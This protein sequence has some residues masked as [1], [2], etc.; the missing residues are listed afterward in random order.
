MEVLLVTQ[1]SAGDVHPAVGIGVELAARGHRVVVGANERFAETIAAAGLKL[2]ALG[3]R[4][5]Y[6]SAAASPELFDGRRGYEAVLR[7][8]VIPLVPAVYDLV[9]SFDPRRTVVAAAPQS[10]GARI[11]QEK[12]GTPLVTLAVQPYLLRSAFDP[13]RGAGLPRLAG[14]PRPLVRAAFAAIDAV[15]LDRVLAPE[16]NAFRARHG[17]PPVRRFFH[18]WC[19]SPAGVLG[20]FPDWMVPPQP[21]WPPNAELTGFI[22]WDPGEEEALPAALTAFLERG[23]PPVVFTPGTAMGQARRFFAAAIAA[24]EALGWRGVLLTP[25]EAHL[26]RPLPASVLHVPWAPLAAL[27]P[28]ARAIVHHGGVGTAAKALRAGVPQLFMPMS[29]DQPDSAARLARL[30]IA[31]VLPPTRFRAP[32]VARALEELVGSEDVA[33]RCRALGGRVDFAA[34]RRAAAAAIERVARAAGVRP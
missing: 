9:A 3:A 31:R 12:L 34:A 6:E 13:P 28:H 21:D 7:R 16:V 4:R 17:L 8:G 23:E 2:A 19:H 27:L 11:A 10:F 20:L 29:Q 24:C 14:L 25:A 22:G 5:A 15:V 26:P 18:R 33:R 1:G 32:A 30:G